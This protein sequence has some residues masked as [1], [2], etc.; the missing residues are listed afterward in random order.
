MDRGHVE[1]VVIEVIVGIH[2]D[3]EV[4]CPK[5]D[6][7]TRVKELEKFDSQLWPVAISRISEKLKVPIPLEELVFCDRDKNIRSI[8]EAVGA[9][10]E[11]IE[12]QPKQKASK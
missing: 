1:K 7:K 8:D 6:K 10:M 5:I 3:L 2:A 9:L 12:K 11:I 4:E